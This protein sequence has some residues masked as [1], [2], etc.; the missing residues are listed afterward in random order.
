MTATPSAAR[1]TRKPAAP[2]LPS[3]VIVDAR[4]E[5]EALEAEIARIFAPY[6]AAGKRPPLIVQMEG[7]DNPDALAAVGMLALEYHRS[8]LTIA[9]PARVPIH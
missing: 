5:G 3:T 6:R 9:S 8:A 4:L 7:E 2:A 1:R